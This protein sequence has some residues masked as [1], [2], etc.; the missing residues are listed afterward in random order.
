[1]DIYWQGSHPDH[2]LILLN[3]VQQRHRCTLRLYRRDLLQLPD[4]PP[5]RVSLL[6]IHAILHKRS[7]PDENVLVL[8]HHPRSLPQRPILALLI[9][10]DLTVSGVPSF[11]ILSEAP[12]IISWICH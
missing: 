3:D 12:P 7:L 6:H 8:L 4:L 5:W 11:T 2:V 9:H 10:F 1:M